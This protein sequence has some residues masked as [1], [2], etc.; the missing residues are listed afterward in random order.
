MKS[1]KP[2]STAEALRLKGA[3]AKKH[4]IAAEMAHADPTGAHWHGSEAREMERAADNTL[5]LPPENVEVGIGGE[6]V[7]LGA[8]AREK[9]GIVDTVRVSPTLSTARASCERMDLAGHAGVLDL[10]ADAAESIQA[11]NSLEKMLAHQLAAAHALAMKHSE[12]AMAHTRSASQDLFGPSRREYHAVEAA[13]DKCRC[14]NDGDLPGWRAGAGETQVRRHP[15]GHRPAPTCHCR[16]R[17]PS[18]H[19]RA[20]T[21]GHWRGRIKE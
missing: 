5:A 18:G 13:R 9:P 15:A 21:V 10:A 7:P 20:T 17:R 19:H 6:I 3:A 1:S 8:D 4:A 11:A 16:R 2:E 12:R 14:K